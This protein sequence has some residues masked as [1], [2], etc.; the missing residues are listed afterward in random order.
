LV[1]CNAPHDTRSLASGCAS[2]LTIHQSPV[3]FLEPSAKADH[4]SGKVGL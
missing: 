4:S 1:D 3:T 2:C